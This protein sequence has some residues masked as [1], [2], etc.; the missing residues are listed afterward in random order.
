MSIEYGSPELQIA[1]SNRLLTKFFA[2]QA[3]ALL[4]CPKDPDSG[5]E[6][7][8][9]LVIDEIV[10]VR[11]DDATAMDVD[12]VPAGGSATSALA[13][14]GKAFNTSRSALASRRIRAV[15]F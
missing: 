11:S 6:L 4:P 13:V 15:R 1:L 7:L 10:T 5:N 3:A 12:N 8:T 2:S 9:D 14:L